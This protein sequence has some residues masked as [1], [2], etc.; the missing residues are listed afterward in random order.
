MSNKIAE[1]TLGKLGPA[2]G[3]FDFDFDMAAPIVGSAPFNEIE[4]FHS[5]DHGQRHEN[6]ATASDDVPSLAQTGKLLDTPEGFKWV[7]NRNGDPALKPTNDAITSMAILVKQFFEDKD[8]RYLG[9]K[10]DPKLF[11]S[12]SRFL[13]CIKG[14]RAATHLESI[15][16]VMGEN[17]EMLH[18]GKQIKQA[19]KC[20]DRIDDRV[21]NSMIMAIGRQAEQEFAT[22][23]YWLS[24]HKNNV[25]R[26]NDRG[27][28]RASEESLMRA[29]ESRA[30]LLVAGQLLDECDKLYDRFNFDARR[31]AKAALD[32][33]GWRQARRILGDEKSSAKRFKE[34]L[35]IREQQLKNINF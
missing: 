16:D 5:P 6:E 17:T 35:S 12:M 21:G 30:Q 14:I 11:A 23:A 22:A 34:K 18:V 31:A 4:S 32:L 28:E 1:K 15:C 7:K 8:A 3:P 20:I 9:L 24:V 27:D 33:M 19:K 10:E 13:H 26:H 25:F 2:T 29:E